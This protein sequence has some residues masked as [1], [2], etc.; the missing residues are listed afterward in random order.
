MPCYL[1]SD[2]TKSTV[3]I[4]DLV[5]EEFFPSMVSG[6]GFTVGND[7]PWEEEFRIN[8]IIMTETSMYTPE[9]STF[10]L[11][12]EVHEPREIYVEGEEEQIEEE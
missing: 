9:R 5:N 10:S 6:G 2:T 11:R 3:G 7:I 8:N 4:L 12:E 1:K